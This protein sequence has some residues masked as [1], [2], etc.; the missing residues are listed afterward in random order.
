MK[1]TKIDVLAIDEM[2]IVDTFTKLIF[3]AE[4]KIDHWESVMVSLLCEYE[5]TLSKASPR[6]VSEYLRSMAVSEMIIAVGHIKQQCDQRNLLAGS[7]NLSSQSI[8]PH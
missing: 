2:A 6:E 4:A 8:S 1:S 3:D 7:K 5:P